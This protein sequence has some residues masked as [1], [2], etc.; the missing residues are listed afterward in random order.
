LRV[1]SAV[2]GTLLFVIGLMLLGFGAATAFN[3]VDNIGRQGPDWICS[4]DGT[5]Q[6]CEFSVGSVSRGQAAI[7]ADLAMTVTGSAL[8]VCGSIF[9][10]IGSSRSARA[11]LAPPTPRPTPAPTAP[12]V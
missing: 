12:P 10:L 9:V 8:A 3:E 5:L 6:K 2:F 11:Q 7:T 1:L 4:T